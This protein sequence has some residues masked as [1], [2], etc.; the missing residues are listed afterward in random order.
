MPVRKK[1]QRFDEFMAIPFRN[2]QNIEKNQKYRA[3]YNTYV[4]NNKIYIKGY[5][6]IEDSYYVHIKV[7]SDS[8]KEGKY[9]YDVV[10][11]FFTDDPK[12]KYSNSLNGYY[13]QFFS[14]S[15]GFIYK[16]AVLYK[17]HNFLIEELYDK[18]DP[19][20]KDVLP[21]KTNPKMELSY[22]KSIYFACMFIADRKF[23]I[24]NKKGFLLQKKVKP[25]KFFMNI[26]DFRSVKLDRDLIK[27]ESS[28]KKQI[29]TIKKESKRKI[30]DSHRKYAKNTTR[31]VSLDTLPTGI[32]RVVKKVA[33][34][35][36]S[37]IKAKKSTRKS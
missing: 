6:E 36:K 33:S 11:R 27:A 8:L 35:R 32:K 20:F 2:D 7:P 28:L 21:E 26:S 4:N 18:L 9:E 16:Y 13:V 3:L 17:N 22:D 14:N 15:P 29:S 25:D 30:N 5:T 24:L 37:K 12:L 19:D 31:K 1:Y 23:R 34:G 10:I